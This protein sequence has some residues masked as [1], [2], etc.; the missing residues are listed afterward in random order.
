MKKDWMS[1][2]VL[3]FIGVLSRLI[4]HPW[5]FTAITAMALYSGVAFKKNKIFMLVPIVTLF[6]SDLYLG[7]HNTLF[8]TYLGFGIVAIMSSSI[9]SQSEFFSNGKNM[10]LMG[11][12]SLI[13]SL[14]FFLVSNFGVWFASGI[15]EKNAAGLVQCFIAAI[16]FLRI[17]ILGDLFYTGVFGV[18]FTI[19]NAKAH[20]SQKPTHMKQR[21]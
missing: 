21:F 17:Q 16:P 3:V 7:F 13:G 4:P 10:V 15:Y 1:F 9:F 5:N 18:I 11:G 20:G 14:L 19:L 6:L 12:V 2:I 8:F